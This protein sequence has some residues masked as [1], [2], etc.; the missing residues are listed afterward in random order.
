MRVTLADGSNTWLGVF[1]AT[2]DWD[3]ASIDITILEADGGPLVGM[4]LLSGFAVYLEVVDGGSVEVSRLP[5]P[6]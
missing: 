4:S 2:L 6:P 3:G 1:L 5:A